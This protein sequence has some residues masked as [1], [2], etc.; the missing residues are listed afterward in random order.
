PDRRRKGAVLSVDR[1]H[2]AEPLVGP[3]DLEE[4]LPGD[5][6]PPGDVLEEGQQVLGT[7]GSTERDEE[8]GVVFAA[9]GTAY[10]GAIM[11]GSSGLCERAGSGRCTDSPNRVDRR[12]AEGH[13]LAPMPIAP[14]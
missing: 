9:P 2:S 10:H 5:P 11:A 3:R 7:L 1:A 14:K 4:P 13:D 6:A 12:W 8:E